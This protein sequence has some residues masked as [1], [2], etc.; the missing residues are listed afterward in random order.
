MYALNQPHELSY[1][2]SSVCPQVPPLISVLLFKLAKEK[3]PRLVHAV[4]NCLPNLGTHKVLTTSGLHCPT[5]QQVSFG[6]CNVLKT[7][8]T[9]SFFVYTFA[10]LVV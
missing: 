4:L 7:T 8:V 9:Q 2:N 6:M 5:L 10:I 1:L 3:N